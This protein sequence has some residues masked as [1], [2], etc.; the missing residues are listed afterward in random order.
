M[1]MGMEKGRVAAALLALLALLGIAAYSLSPEEQPVLVG[2]E[3]SS[4]PS[5]ESYRPIPGQDQAVAREELGNPFDVLH[6]KRREETTPAQPQSEGATAPAPPIP[7][8]P[9]VNAPEEA[10]PVQRE[11]QAQPV[12]TGILR[13]DKDAL[14][15]LSVGGAS[16]SVAVGESLS[17]FTVERIEEGGVLV[18]SASGEQY[19]PLAQ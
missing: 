16:E 19:L 4:G 6:G 2:G 14:A 10:T 9:A 5:Q 11:P 15:I 13:S 7:V 12:V 3:E 17:G 1:P 18:H 8:V